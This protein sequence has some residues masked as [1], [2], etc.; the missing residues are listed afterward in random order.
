MN[1]KRRDADTEIAIVAIHSITDAAKI[2]G[3]HP[4]TVRA[5]KRRVPVTCK[6]CR[7][8]R[9]L[10]AYARVGDGYDD[11]CTPCRGRAAR[12][13]ARQL[14]YNRGLGRQQQTA[15]RAAAVPLAGEW[16]DAAACRGH[17]TELFFAIGSG[18][19]AQAQNDEA[20]Q[21][22][23]ACPVLKVCREWALKTDQAAGV[24]GGLT[25]AERRALKS[26]KSRGATSA[27]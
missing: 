19:A 11:V 7:T 13:R 17:D 9:T 14:A 1:S 6:A 4:N 8:T 16:R 23:A 3:I 27:A 18:D 2:L 20:K 25:E 15:G 26:G 12:E 22:C 24:F 5:L 21:V 10:T